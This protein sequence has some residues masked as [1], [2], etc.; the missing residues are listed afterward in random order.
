MQ[1]GHPCLLLYLDNFAVLWQA[2]SVWIKKVTWSAFL[3]SQNILNRLA[4]IAWNF[5][6]LIYLIIDFTTSLSIL[7]KFLDIKIYLWTQHISSILWF[8]SLSILTSHFFPHNNKFLCQRTFPS[9][10]VCIIWYKNFKFV[11]HDVCSYT[12]YVPCTKAI[13]NFFNSFCDVHLGIY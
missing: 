13:R 4:H 11:C 10:F 5:I 7:G 8:E 6:I 3:S 9:P 2:L 12:V 1:W